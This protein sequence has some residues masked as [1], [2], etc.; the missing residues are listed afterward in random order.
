MVPIGRLGTIVNLLTQRIYIGMK[1]EM[2]FF[3]ILIDLILR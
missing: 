3:G 2:N 1:G